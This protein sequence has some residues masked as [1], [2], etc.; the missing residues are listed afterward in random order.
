MSSTSDMSSG[1]FVTL[2]NQTKNAAGDV[3]DNFSQV[4]ADF[5][6]AMS[7]ASPGHTHDGNDSRKLSVGGGLTPNEL[8]RFQLMGIFT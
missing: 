6:N 4:I 5:N 2:E 1:D 3:N 7:T 8:F